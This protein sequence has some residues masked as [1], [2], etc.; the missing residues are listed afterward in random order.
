L[1]R[2]AVTSVKALFSNTMAIMSDF[3]MVLLIPVCL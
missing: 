2:S 3:F 1:S